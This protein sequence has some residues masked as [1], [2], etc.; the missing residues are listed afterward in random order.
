MNETRKDEAK[1]DGALRAAIVSFRLGGPDGVSVE[2]RKWKSALEAIGFE[3]V[4][5]AGQGPVDHL[6]PG[7]AIDAAVAPRAE[8]FEEAVCDADLVVVENLLSLPLNAGAAEVVGSV[9]RGRPA[10]VRHHDLP[11]QRERFANAPPPPSDDAWVAVTIN[12]LSAVELEE[13]AG[14][15]ATVLYNRFDTD[16]PRGDR[17]GARAELGVEPGELLFLQPTRALPRKNVPGGLSYAETHG[18]TY[19]LLGEAEDGYDDE[20]SRV[21]RGAKTRVIRGYGPSGAGENVLDAYAACDVVL[22]PST[23][24]GFGNPAVESAV[25][26]RPLV[27]GPYPVGRE[28]R[29]HGFE[30]FDLA[31]PGALAKWIEAPCDEMLARNHE[32]ARR[33]FSTS[34]LPRALATLLHENGLPL[35]FWPMSGECA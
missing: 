4:E 1:T 29:A 17:E 28:L 32:V 10:V 35:P 7:L 6:L 8:E 30:W 21:L 23:W 27:I 20:L 19:W 13:R 3:V 31:D 33:H 18:A 22:L 16:A 25:H 11:W 14:V 5:V 9:L 26:F 12:E 24:E 2:A 15:R 34:E